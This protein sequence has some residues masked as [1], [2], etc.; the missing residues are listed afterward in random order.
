[1]RKRGLVLS[2]LGSVLLIA[3]E[4]TGQPRAADPAS[5]P[6]D[7][8]VLQLGTTSDMGRL[9]WSIAER[10]GTLRAIERRH[11]VRIDIIRFANEADAVAAYGRRDIDAVTSTLSTMIGTV[12]AEPRDTHVV[13]VTDFSR[14]A[15]GLISRTVRHPRD[16][17]GQ[18]IHLPLNTASHYLL[19]RVLER[20]GLDM[21]DVKLVNTPAPRLLERAIRGEIN[22]MV[23]GAPVL[24]QLQ[25]LPEFRSIST[26]R[27]L[28]GELIG[29]VMVDG[30]LID[31]KPRLGHALVEAWF[32]AVG[33]VLLDAETFTDAG[34]EALANL[35][36]LSE[37][38]VARFLSPRDLVANAQASL[39]LM[40]GRNL[41]RT[42]LGAQRFRL[43]ARAFGCTRSSTESCVFT[44]DGNRITNGVGTE[45]Y[46]N[47]QFLR[48][49]RNGGD[50]D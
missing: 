5:R 30:A 6:D 10:A 13:V 3:C 46:L 39:G 50:D 25:V 7:V 29:G 47:G 28:G 15:H 27:S 41:D 14:G 2:L 20:A 8:E 1:M 19:F 23:V 32:E 24:G 12:E 45:I 17:R 16:L 43:D 38:Q 31:R 36:G 18:T 33:E 22:T 48:Q 42:I 4:E 37:T 44:R 26:S 35:S 11:D 34:L 49:W 40:A 9:P 21:G